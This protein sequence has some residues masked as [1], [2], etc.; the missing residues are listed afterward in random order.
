LNL[1]FGK[2]DQMQPIT[3]YFSQVRL[4]DGSY[5]KP[6]THLD[7]TSS[8]HFVIGYDQYMNEYLRF[9][10]ETYLQLI[11]NVPV[12]KGSRSPYSMLNQGASF[13]IGAPDTLYNGGRGRNY[14][15]ELTLEHFLHNGLYFLLT[16]S[17]YDSKYY[18]SDEVWRN[19]AF[20]GNY[21]FNVLAGKEFNLNRSENKRKS[22]TL[23]T[24]A[25]LTYAGGQHYTPIDPVKSKNEGRAVFIDNEAYSKQFNNYFRFDFKVVLKR[26]GKK[27]TQEWGIDIQN[28]FNTKNVF[29]QKYNTRTGDVTNTYQVG[30]MII[31]QYT[32][33]F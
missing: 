23:S 11:Q 13:Y 16:A 4:N 33:T 14:G 27:T 3:I 9:K 15:L 17:L 26:N 24:D 22:L 29:M 6:N 32:I 31:P 2:H 8:Y 21:I 7:F 10:A 19:T 18:G 30:R 5:Y 12:D 25:K 1:G 20:N 28:F